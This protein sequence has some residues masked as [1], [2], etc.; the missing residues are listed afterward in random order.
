M[1]GDWHPGR[2]DGFLPCLLYELPALWPE[3]KE[4]IM[5]KISLFLIISLLFSLPLAAQIFP[6][7]QTN[8]VVDGSFGTNEYPPKLYNSRICVLDMPRVGIPVTCTS[9]S[10]RQP[11]DGYPWALDPTGCMGGLISSLAMMQFQAKSSARK[12]VADTATAHPHQRFLYR[13]RSRRQEVRP[14]LSSRYL[15]QSLI[16]EGTSVL[17]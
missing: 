9:F 17:L 3:T 14:P 2:L 12:L 1:G 10:K 8:P 5:R 13:A 6:S 4:K 11:Q 7:S 16:Q 15:P